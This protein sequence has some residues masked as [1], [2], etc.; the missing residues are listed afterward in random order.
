MYSYLN[1][2]HRFKSLFNKIQQNDVVKDG[3]V[4]S[5]VIINVW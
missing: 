4:G 5:Y 3:I 1:I 2:D